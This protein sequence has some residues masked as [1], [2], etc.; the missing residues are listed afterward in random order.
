MNKLQIKIRDR[1]YTMR[2]DEDPAR[3]MKI[4]SNL[5]EKI[6][7]FAASMR[8]RPEAEI[9]TIT[10]FDLMEQVDDLIDAEAKLED[11]L[12]N[13]KQLLEKIEQENKQLLTDNMHSAES[14]LV[15]IAMVKEQENEALR[16]KIQEYEKEWDEQ[17]K[18]VY[19]SAIDEANKN[20][21][22]KEFENQKLKETLD[23]FERIFDDFAKTKEGDILRMQEEIEALK[24]KLAEVDDGQLTL[25]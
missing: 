14:E 24:L 6:V 7:E 3:M 10:A 8:G 18:N 17:T 9:L 4:A 22:L 1:V 23:N 16:I 11:D 21:E 15:Q 13:L 20:A 5:D 2:T 25:A 19:Q 12:Q